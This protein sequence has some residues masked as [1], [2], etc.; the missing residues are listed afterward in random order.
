M[1]IDIEKALKNVPIVSL[2]DKN[3]D[4]YALMEKYNICG[5]IKAKVSYFMIKTALKEGKLDKNKILL[6]ASSGNTAIALAYFGKIF[7]IKIKII[8]P[9]NTAICKKKLITSYG[10][11]IVEVEGITDDCIKYRDE[12]YAQDKEKYFLPDQFTNYANFNAHYN[13]TGPRIE[14]ELGTNLDFFCAGLGTSGT[15]LGTAKYLKQKNPNIKII[16]I[17]PIE[18]VE[19]LRNFKTTKLKIP[20]YEEYKHLI[21]KVIDVS[22]EDIEIGL[23]LYLN[24]GYL[25][26]LSS[27][28]V[29]SGLT[30]YLKDKKGLKGCVIAPD[31][32]DFYLDKVGNYVNMQNISCS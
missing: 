30:Q 18:R 26:G 16:A 10:A 4:T 14:E 5:S 32:G 15:L 19:G 2:C 28:A 3:N 22:E 13:L 8:L 20:F 17:N 12:L 21:D 25:V 23:G 31:G 1:K 11:E 29:L 9:T 27:G 7:D 6:E 24:R